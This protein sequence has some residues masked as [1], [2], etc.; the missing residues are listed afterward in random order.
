MS[1]AWLKVFHLVFIVSWFAGLLY[2]PR[3]FV[4][5]A[6]NEHSESFAVFEVME[7]R[8]FSIMTVGAVLTIV[9]GIG[10]LLTNP[11][12]YLTQAWMYWKL[13]LVAALLIYHGWCWQHI[14]SFKLNKNR[15]SHIWFRWFNE[16]PI[17]F[18]FGI[19]ILVLVKPNL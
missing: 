13:A 10:A 14:Q 12:Y 11:S 2:L 5:H 3:L 17:L 15:H 4:Y 8:L 9:F 19:A 7:R 16:A 18:L 1:L 6:Q